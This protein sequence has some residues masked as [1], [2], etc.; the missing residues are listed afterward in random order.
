MPGPNASLLITKAFPDADFLPFEMPGEFL[1]PDLLPERYAE[2][3]PYKMP[4]EALEYYTTFT[5]RTGKPHPLGL[6]A[7]RRLY[8][9]PGK[10]F[11]ASK[12]NRIADR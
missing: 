4:S 10:Q 9:H 6:I 7:F 1:Q 12:M 3:L 11:R 8:S 2:I 5:I